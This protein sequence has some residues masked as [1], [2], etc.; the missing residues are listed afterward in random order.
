MICDEKK[1]QNQV[2]HY[3]EKPETFV[4]TYI[5]CGLYMFNIGVLNLIKEIGDNVNKQRVEEHKY[6][7][8]LLFAFLFL[9]IYIYIKIYS[10]TKSNQM[11]YSVPDD[12]LSLEHD[13]VVSLINKGLVYSYKYNGFWCPIKTPNSLIYCNEFLIQYYRENMS[14]LQLVY[15]CSNKET[16]KSVYIHNSTQISKNTFI[17]PNVY[18]GKNC[19]I[20]EGTRISN[21][22]IHDG[23]TIG[24]NCCIKYSIIESQVNIGNWCRIVGEKTDIYT[25]DN[26]DKICIIGSD[27]EILSEVAVNCSVILPYKVIKEC[28][29]SQIIL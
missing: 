5:N 11:L 14:K 17:G 18:I 8:I 22:I 2:I 24:C 15:S 19:K 13:L 28:V 29:N 21:T 23:V 10:S 27:V 9:F 6:I 20:G 12:Y 16:D 26:A 1:K 3:A 4:S 7:N 25:Y